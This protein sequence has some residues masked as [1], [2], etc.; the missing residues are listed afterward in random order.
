VPESIRSIDVAKLLSLRQWTQIFWERYF[1]SIEKIVHTTLEVSSFQRTSKRCVTNYKWLQIVFDRVSQEVGAGARNGLI[2]NSAPG[3]LFSLPQ[4]SD[5]WSQYPFYAEAIGSEVSLNFT[6]VIYSHPATTNIS[7]NANTPL[8]RL[9][10]SLGKSRHI[11]RVI[12][13]LS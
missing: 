13:F 1:S 2:W 6:A 5:T 7:P 3:A 8:I 12:I 11:S 4:F 10:K 9:L